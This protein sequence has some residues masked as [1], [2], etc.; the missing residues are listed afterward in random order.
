MAKILIVE[1]DVELTV[2]LEAYLAAQAH[3]VEI[4]HTGRHGEDL[5]K[6]YEYDLLI[7][8]WRL[9]DL[10][11]P[12]FCLNFRKKGGKL[13]ILMLT[14]KTEIEHKEYGLDAGV[15]DYM[16][17]PF[18]MREL[19]A[20]VRAL[21]R[22]P[23]VPLEPV[24]K[25]KE[26][27][28]NPSTR[29]VTRAGAP[30]KIYPKEFAILEYLMRNPNR[31]ISWQALINHVWKSD[32]GVGLEGLRTCINRLRKQIDVSGQPSL[33]ENVHGVGY[34]LRTDDHPNAPSEKPPA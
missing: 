7:L 33:I 8:D 3:S 18:D 31:V 29:E 27:S 11:G 19:G 32:E 25:A 14:G 12:E 4:V 30:L 28:L 13:P 24:L 10:P 1:D 16:T 20:R 2:L 22:R 26:L 34:I 17:K 15:D 6:R 5:L 9:P 23:H 21:L